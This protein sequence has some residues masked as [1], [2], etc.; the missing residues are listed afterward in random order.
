[1][2]GA[3][4]PQRRRLEVVITTL[5]DAVEYAEQLFLE[6][7]LYFGHGSF[8]AFDEVVYLV[9]S[10]LKLPLDELDGVWNRTVNDAEREAVLRIIHRRVDERIPAAYLTNEAFLGPYRFYVDERVIV[11]RSFIAELLRDELSPWIADAERVSTS[12][13][14]SGTISRAASGCRASLFRQ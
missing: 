4:E 8:D 5:G 9:L 3:I 13:R 6:A 11:P 7:G 14:R 12:C 1:M 2:S 10:A